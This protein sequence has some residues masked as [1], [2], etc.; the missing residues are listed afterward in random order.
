MPQFP[1]CRKTSQLTRWTISRIIRSDQSKLMNNQSSPTGSGPSTPPPLHA[2]QLTTFPVVALII[3]HFL[4]CGLFSFIWL[5]LM[6]GNS[7]ASGPTIPPLPGPSAFASSPSSTYTG[8][9]SPCA[10]CAC[11]SM[12]NAASTACLPVTCAASLPP[13]VSSKSF[14]TS[15]S[16]SAI[17]S[18]CRSTSA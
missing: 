9:F 16:F 8:F 12:N 5:N 10:V 6:H 4:T 3:L 18:L 11:A 7:R 2:H 15:T 17:P 14:H 13:R 1:P